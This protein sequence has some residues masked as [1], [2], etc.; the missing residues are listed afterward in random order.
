[1]ARILGEKRPVIVCECNPD[2][3]YGH[4]QDILRDA[5]YTFFHVRDSGPVERP[6]IEPD[7]KQQF[8]NYACVPAENT[9]MRALVAGLTRAGALG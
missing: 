9:T 8:R 1:M 5:G 6:R 2:G 3:P 4:V 7:P